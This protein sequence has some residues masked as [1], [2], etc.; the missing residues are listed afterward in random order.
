MRPPRVFISYCRKRGDLDDADWVARVMEIARSLQADGYAVWDD[1]AVP[2]VTD[3]FGAWMERGL[4]CID[5]VVVVCTPEYHARWQAGPTTGAGW[6]SKL[7]RVGTSRG[8]VAPIVAAVVKGR[9]QREDIPPALEQNYVELAAGGVTADRYA[10]PGYVKL[11]RQ[12]GLFG[13]RE[14]VAELKET[15]TLRRPQDGRQEQVQ[16]VLQAAGKIEEGSWLVKE[17]VGALVEVLRGRLPAEHADAATVLAAPE[18]DRPLVLRGLLL[19]LTEA[20]TADPV[21]ELLRELAPR[22]Q[23]QAALGVPDVLYARVERQGADK[24]VWT[25]ARFRGP[26]FFG[27]RRA[28]RGAGPDG[29]AAALADEAATFAGLAKPEALR[30]A[31][32]VDADEEVP[33]ELLRGRS[34]RG[35]PSLTRRFRS[36][37][38]WPMY[39]SRPASPMPPEL[40]HP[41][42]HAST[43]MITADPPSHEHWYDAREG[44]VAVLVGPAVNRR[45]AV[46]T[47][48]NLLTLLLPDLA[49][50]D[51]L[52]PAG[53]GRPAAEVV[54]L[55]RPGRA[56]D[57]HCLAI[58]TD[59]ELH[60]FD[61][62][63]RSL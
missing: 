2:C 45:D 56:D 30:V 19:V 40:V 12:L 8:R 59:A 47:H 61:T 38:L 7:L 41:H 21:G 44:R 23:G 42:G 49:H 4:A 31:L 39:D 33:P 50:A 63:A 15:D 14:G 36:V 13:R 34:A 3:D 48:V 9:G 60:P 35:Q 26:P 6:E 51:R 16:E 55:T 1:E 29:V 27:E 54:A 11:L 57:P 62:L 28:A 58:W 46:D 22:P 17:K 18:A 32:V 37:S 20:A 52:V 25:Q 5:I 10:D 24:V 43:A 53:D